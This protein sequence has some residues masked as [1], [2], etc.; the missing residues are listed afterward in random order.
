MA[1]I[2]S[3]TFDA[4]YPAKGAFMTENETAA[5]KGS[6]FNLAGAVAYAADSV[7]SK[8]LLKKESGNVTLFSFD[9]GQGLSEHTAPFDAMVQILD[10]SAQI[11]IGEEQKTVAAGEMIVMPANVPHALQAKERFKMLLVMI[12]SE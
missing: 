12:K 4:P 5:L 6:P 9:Q 11:R 10:G 3:Q 2:D 1:T 7:V 8:T